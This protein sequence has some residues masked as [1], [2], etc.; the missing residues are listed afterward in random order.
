MTDVRWGDLSALREREGGELG[1]RGGREE[2]QR[3]VRSVTRTCDGQYWAYPCAIHRLTAARFREADA[4]QETSS[5]FQAGVRLSRDIGTTS[6]CNQKKRVQGKQQQLRLAWRRC[7]LLAGRTESSTRM[8]GTTPST[9]SGRHR[10]QDD[11]VA[12]L[13]GPVGYRLVAGAGGCPQTVTRRSR[14][15]RDSCAAPEVG[16]SRAPAGLG[17][18]QLQ[19]SACKITRLERSGGTCGV[20]RRQTGVSELCD[21]QPIA[22]SDLR[23]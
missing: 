4:D 5:V 19:H 20:H 6:I 2:P 14:K 13:H 18:H 9:R 23:D 17:S 21:L 15:N 3:C 22:C 7:L 11:I 8:G 10:C 1:A 16:F 12:R